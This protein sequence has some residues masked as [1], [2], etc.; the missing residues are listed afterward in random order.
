[1]QV[2]L[3]QG[4]AVHDFFYTF[5]KVREDY[6]DIAAFV[7]ARRLSKSTGPFAFDVK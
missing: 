4:F 2:V 6:N 5:V 7:Q 3:V 1:M